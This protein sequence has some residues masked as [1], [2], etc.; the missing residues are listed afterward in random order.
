LGLS[1]SPPTFLSEFFS[2][3]PTQT[4][5]YFPPL[6]PPLP[7]PLSADARPASV[8]QCIRCRSE[9]IIFVKLS[10]KKLFFSTQKKNQNKR[11]RELKNL[12]R[13]NGEREKTISD[14][15]N[16]QTDKKKL[17][18]LLPIEFLTAVID[19]YES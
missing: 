17:L 3:A 4:L 8:R 14:F 1:P 9:V 15:L 10:S 19:F 7:L 16:E 5:S 18:L 13:K 12:C 2:N 11:P 6:S